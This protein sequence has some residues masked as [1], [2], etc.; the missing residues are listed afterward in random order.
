ML[1]ISRK[2][3]TAGSSESVASFLS[4]AS[5]FE[6]QRGCPEHPSA[7]TDLTEVSETGLSSGV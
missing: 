2:H 7:L 6:L 1:K 5:F 4:R 3:R